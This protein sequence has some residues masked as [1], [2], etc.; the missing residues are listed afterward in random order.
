MRQKISTFEIKNLD[1]PL[2]SFVIKSVDLSLLKSE[3]H[4]KLADMPDF[5]SGEP[6]VIDLSGLNAQDH[7]ALDLK[8]VKDLLTA[9]R[10]QPWAIKSQDAHFKELGQQ[11][12]LLEISAF[13][14]AHPHTSKETKGTSKTDLPIAPP[15]QVERVVEIKEVIKE[16]P[17]DKP[18]TMVITKP[19]R[20][21]QHIY[22]RGGD[23]VILAMVNAGAEVMADGNIHVYAPLRGKAI[24][25]A[26]GDV[27]ARIFTSCLEAELVSIAG[28]Y[29]TSDTALPK[30][31]LGQS[32]Q[33]YLEEDKLVMR[34][35]D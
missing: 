1:L 16:I 23:L 13:L 4:Q 27:T 19:L 20:S 9:Y 18:P 32:A 6:A 12:G 33:I 21:G 29:R 34:K 15:T 14:P 35:L 31:V 3:L 17:T 22:A 8:G 5:F 25:G 24:A 10:L 7:G 28:T 30:E 26:K 11:I 2:I